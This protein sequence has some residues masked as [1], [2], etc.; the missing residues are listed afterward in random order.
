M[1]CTCKLLLVALKVKPI[2]DFNQTATEVSNEKRPEK[3][4]K[5]RKIEKEITINGYME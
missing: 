2:N 4:N 3:I 5:R 1:I